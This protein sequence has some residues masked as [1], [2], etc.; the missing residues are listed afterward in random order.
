MPVNDVSVLL[1]SVSA[2]SVLSPRWVSGYAG[3]VLSM[4]N[5]SSSANTEKYSKGIL[6]KPKTQGGTSKRW[7]CAKEAFLLS[8]GIILNI[9]TIR[10]WILEG[11]APKAPRPRE[12]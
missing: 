6:F 1:F 3:I 12:S 9:L 10:N 2:I 8:Y 4:R 5:K 11:L 7:S